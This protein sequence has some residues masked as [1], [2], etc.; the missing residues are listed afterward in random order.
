MLEQAKTAILENIKR[1][2]D[3]DTFNVSDIKTLANAYATLVGAECSAAM[4]KWQTHCDCSEC[5]G[6]NGLDVDVLA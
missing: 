2:A 1:G 4:T 5:R 3:D 6:D